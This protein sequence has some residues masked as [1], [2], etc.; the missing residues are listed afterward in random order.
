MLGSLARA[1]L[2]LVETMFLVEAL[3]AFCSSTEQSLWKFSMIE[4]FPL[5]SNVPNSK[6]RTVNKIK[7]AEKTFYRK[8]KQAHNEPPKRVHV[9]S[10]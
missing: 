2:K 10:A 1:Q 3:F 7:F 5:A 8:G 6:L 9:R 4:Y